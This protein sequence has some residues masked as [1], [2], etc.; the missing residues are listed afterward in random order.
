MIDILVS[1]KILTHL[2]ISF[3]QEEN[4]LDNIIS[5]ALVK[6]NPHQSTRDLA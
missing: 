3:S 4:A 6:A 1:F 5:K 2:L